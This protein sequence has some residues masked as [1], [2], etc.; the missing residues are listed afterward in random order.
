MNVV[1]ISGGNENGSKTPAIWQ[2]FYFSKRVQLEPK[3]C[4]LSTI[5]VWFSVSGERTY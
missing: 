4:P 1:G 3:P 5:Q 2:I